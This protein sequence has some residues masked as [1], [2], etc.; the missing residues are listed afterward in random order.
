[1]VKNF[2]I[3]NDERWEKIN[4]EQYDLLEKYQNKLNPVFYTA[5]R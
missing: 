4:D 3:K 5:V 1:M 2:T